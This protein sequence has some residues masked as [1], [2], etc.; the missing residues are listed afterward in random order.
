MR[1]IS[2]NSELSKQLVR[3]VAEYPHIAIATAWASADTE[4]FRALVRHRRRLAQAV[5]GTHFYQT[6]PDVLDQFIESNNVKFMLQPDGVFH[7]KVYVFWS[8][9][10]WEVILGSPNLTHGALTKN[11]ELAMLVTSND[12]QPEMKDQILQVIGSY[13]DAARSVSRSEA[14]SYRAIWRLKA[15]DLS[16]VADEFG[17]KPATKPAVQSKVMSMEWDA[18]LAE[19]KKDQSHGFKERLAMLAAVRRLFDKNP[20]FND[21][22][23]DGRLGISGFSSNAVPNPKWFGSMQ[24]AGTFRHLINKESEAFSLALDEIPAEGEVLR[25]HYDA[26]IGQYVSAFHAGRHGLGT[27]TR[28]L[29]MKRP[30]VFLCV[31]AKN[32]KRLAE[33]IGIVRVDRLDYERYW[34]EVVLRLMA[35]PWWQAPEPDEPGAKAAWHARSAMLDA[36]FYETKVK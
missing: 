26:F 33:D 34:D 32:R 11:A 24:G 14:E 4:V 12:G 15:R 5:I 21:I 6:H 16:R 7:P 18:Y 35:S 9:N 19:L 8:A 30:D 28:L 31:D 10:A 3:L 13:F 17:E 27:A 2:T 36:I 22:S 1:V 25:E 20:R 29:A 23:I